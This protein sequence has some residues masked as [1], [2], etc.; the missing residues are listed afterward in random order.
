MNNPGI[1][2]EEASDFIDKQLQGRVGEKHVKVDEQ[3]AVF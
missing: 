3:D 2:P 1:S